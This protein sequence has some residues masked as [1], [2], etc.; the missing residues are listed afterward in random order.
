MVKISEICVQLLNSHMFHKKLKPT[1]GRLQNW[2]QTR[3]NVSAC[4]YVWE[5]SYSFFFHS[6]QWKKTML[7]EFQVLFLLLI[8][9]W[10]GPFTFGNLA[11]SFSLCDMSVVWTHN[12][13]PV[14][15]N[16][17]ILCFLF[18][19]SMKCMMLLISHSKFF[20]CL[21]SRIYILS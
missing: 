7:T 13:C 3:K 9:N 1:V 14:L 16:L 2:C 20:A 11:W 12:I 18:L 4:S 10:S 21:N 6:Q 5:L 8:L 17:G 19:P 15:N